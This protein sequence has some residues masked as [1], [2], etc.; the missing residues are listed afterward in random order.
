FNYQGTALSNWAIDNA[1]LQIPPVPI[2]YAWTLTDPAGVPSSY[3]LNATNQAIVRGSPPA[4]GTYVYSV[5][6]TYGNCPAGSAN[7]TVVVLPRPV[8]AITGGATTVCPGSTNTFSAPA[9]AGY[10]YQWSITGGGVIS[11]SSTSQTVTVIA[12]NSCG[13]YQLTL[14]TFLN[15]CASNTP[16][17]VTVNVVDNTAPVAPAPPAT[18][19]VQ[20]LANVPP[21]GALTATDNCGNITVASVDTQ[22]TTGCGFTITR[23][24]TFTDACNNSS[25]VSQTINVLDNTPPVAPTAPATLNVQCLADVPVPGTL[26]ATDNCSGIITTPG[27]DVQVAVG[28]GYTIT[29]TWTFTD[30]CNNSSSVSQTINVLDD[31]PPVINCPPAQIFCEINSNTYTIPPLIASDN[32]SGALNITFQ[33]TGATTRSGS[34]NDASG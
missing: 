29:R 15:G 25:S 20:C 13:T 2:T 26:T 12:N 7:V 9:I 32:C 21:P 27:V 11:G 23:T 1:G 34:G 30:A 16:C 18:L 24:W 31:T 14:R 17:T 5:T 8:C 28:C 10:T 4:P 6:T 33:I 3:Y 22:V 19:N